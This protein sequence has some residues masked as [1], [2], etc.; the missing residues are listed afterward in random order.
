MTFLEK[1][2]F[3]RQSPEARSLNE[4]EA[5][6]KEVSNSQ[7]Y[8]VRNLSID[9]CLFKSSTT[10]IPYNNVPSEIIIGIS[11][12]VVISDSRFMH[13][14]KS[15]IALIDDMQNVEIVNNEFFIPQNMGTNSYVLNILGQ[16][17]TG[18]VA[19]HNSGSN[20]YYDNLKNLRI[21]DNVFKVL[22]PESVEDLILGGIHVETGNTEDIHINN[23]SF[24]H[25][26]QPIFAFQVAGVIAS[27][28]LSNTFDEYDSAIRFS[29][30]N[31]SI[32]AS[33]NTFLN[34]NSALVILDSYLKNH[35]AYDYSNNFNGCSSCIVNMQPWGLF[36]YGI[37][38]SSG[39][40]I[41]PTFSGPGAVAYIATSSILNCSSAGGNPNK[42]L[43]KSVESFD[44]FYNSDA[45]SISNLPAKS[46]LKLVDGFGKIIYTLNTMN[47]D[48]EIQISHLNKEI[49]YLI[50]SY[51]GEEFVEKIIKT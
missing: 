22:D 12:D 31:P 28:I 5:F 33:C 43:L 24:E 7:F 46:T 38:T 26:D 11:K 25:F 45:I 10:G 37:H 39:A 6:L 36:K 18:I 9:K 42:R 32:D 20:L 23:N 50:I 3:V 2:T 49:Y 4:N 21:E 19:H 1:H 40:P 29:G 17:Y 13:P 30:V 41:G 16:H 34:G 8:S 15:G 48:V 27:H 35:D 51:S 14:M 44:L 47:H